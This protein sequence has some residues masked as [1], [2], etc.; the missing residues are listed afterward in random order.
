MFLREV[1][2]DLD[3]RAIRHILRMFEGFLP[4]GK[5][6]ARVREF[7]QHDEVRT[8]FDRLLGHAQ[9]VPQI[10]L[11]VLHPD[12]WIKLHHRYPDGTHHLFHV[13]AHS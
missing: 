10:A 4:A 7:R 12:L 1:H 3:A 11:T 8:S 5:E 2:P 9:A 13:F 6:I